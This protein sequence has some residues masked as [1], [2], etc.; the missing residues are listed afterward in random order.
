MNSLPQSD[1]SPQIRAKS[2]DN[3]KEV[4]NAFD[5]GDSFADEFDPLKQTLDKAGGGDKTEMFVVYLFSSERRAESATDDVEDSV[6][7]KSLDV[8]LADLKSD[9]EFVTFRATIYEE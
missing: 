9:G 5:Q 3:R 1:N 2:L 7:A 6:N 4:I 8:D